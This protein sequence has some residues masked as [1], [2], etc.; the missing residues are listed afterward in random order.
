MPSAAQLRLRTWLFWAVPVVLLALPL[1]LNPYLQ[2]I[3]NAMLIYVL[4]TLGF[5]VVIGNLGQLAFANTAFFGIGAYIS[6]IASASLGLPWLLTIPLAGLLAACGGFLTSAAALRGIR[7]YY[8]AIITL[9]FGELMRWSYIHAKAVTGGTDGLALPRETLL[10]YALSD[11]A[12]NYYV[13]LAVAV[14]LIKATLN[15]MRSRLGRAIVAV[16]ENEVATASLGIPTARVIVVSFMWSGFVTGCAGALFARHTGHVFPEAFGMLHLIASF[17]MVLVGGLG[18]VLGA[19]LGAVTLTALPEYLRAFP[20]MEELFFG[21]VVV[22]V[23]I[24]M[25]KGLASLLRRCSPLFV[26]RFYRE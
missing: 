12:V 13:C 5:G 3:A 21:L 8:L 18:S 16:R 14:L 17:A 6:A 9:A 23:L 10:G 15:L 19:V 1:L 4:V 24:L 11:D 22:A 2:Y 26:E 7:A 25:P 20:G